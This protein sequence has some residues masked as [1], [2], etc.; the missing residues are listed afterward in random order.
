MV[1]YIHVFVLQ[2]PEIWCLAE[3]HNH[4]CEKQYTG[5]DTDRLC[6]DI[7]YLCG[8]WTLSESQLYK[9]DK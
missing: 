9:T 3:I 4:L 7:Y 1:T 2:C 6:G 5:D 8:V